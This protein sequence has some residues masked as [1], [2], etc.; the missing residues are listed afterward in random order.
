MQKAIN[1]KETSMADDK[2]TNDPK[3]TENE[4]EETEVEA[5]EINSVDDIA[6]FVEALAQ[7]GVSG[8]TARSY[9]AKDGFR[10]IHPLLNTSPEVLATMAG[11]ISY[12]L[13][14]QSANEEEGA[15]EALALSIE[16]AENVTS[17]KA[18]T[19]KLRSYCATAL[20]FGYGS[21]IG[22]ENAEIDELDMHDMAKIVTAFLGAQ[23]GA[24]V[25]ADFKAWADDLVAQAG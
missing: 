10:S 15:A 20:D 1:Q 14:E 13:A 11:C 7:D 5:I 12:A 22:N 24:K 21:A 8:P 3:A 25:D 19:V 2:G 6:G 9:R 17:L 23:K 4:S 18:N 16:Y